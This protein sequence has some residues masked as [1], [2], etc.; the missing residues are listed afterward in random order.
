MVKV[1]QD[2][3]VTFHVEGET[4]PSTEYGEITSRNGLTDEVSAYV[5][6]KIGKKY[7]VEIRFK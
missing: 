2:F 4:S 3:E 5:E 7:W 1:G 6:S